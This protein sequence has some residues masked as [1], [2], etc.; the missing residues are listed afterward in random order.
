MTPA[1][2]P[3]VFAGTDLW[4]SPDPLDQEQARTICA[5]CPL[6]AACDRAAVDERWGVW[7][8]RSRE[9]KPPQMVNPPA[10]LRERVRAV[11]G[12]GSHASYTR[13]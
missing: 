4:F 1:C 3:H 10:R 12:C 8:G 2:R 7:A 13:G 9:P 5:S 11:A 6:L